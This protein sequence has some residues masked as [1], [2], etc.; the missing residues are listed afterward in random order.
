MKD[1]ILTTEAAQQLFPG[2]SILKIHSVLGGDG[3]EIL[4]DGTGWIR[5]KNGPYK[6]APADAE[7]LGKCAAASSRLSTWVRSGNQE[8]KIKAL[9]AACSLA[10]LN[11][12][13]LSDEDR[14]RIARVAAEIAER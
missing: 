1:Q 13:D 9:R 6:L 7:A 12:H 4:P 5:S 14:G 11:G 2:E 8:E 10:L 3:Y